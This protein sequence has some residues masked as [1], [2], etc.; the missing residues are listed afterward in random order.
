MQLPVRTL[1]LLF[2][3]DGLEKKIPLL[4]F[5]QIKL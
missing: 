5:A 1:M 2:T 3:M 4:T